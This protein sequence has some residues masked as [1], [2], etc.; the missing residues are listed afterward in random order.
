[1]LAGHLARVHLIVASAMNTLRTVV[2]LSMLAMLSGCPKPPAQQ[3]LPP[4][5][6][7][8]TL[9][10]EAEAES[11]WTGR[12]VS[13]HGANGTGDG[14]AASALTP[15]PRNFQDGSWHS[16]ATDEHLRK[17]LVEGGASVGLSPLMPP[18]ADLATKPLVRDAI[19]ARIRRLMRDQ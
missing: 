2:S 4:P 14:P 17:I 16:R 15:R 13:C 11:I 8:P 18:N 12:C 7:E 19:I 6:A 1:V 9:T 3:P 5:A 10:P